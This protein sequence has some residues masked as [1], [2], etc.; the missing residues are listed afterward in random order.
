MIS[1]QAKCNS[2]PFSFNVTLTGVVSLNFEVEDISF[3]FFEVGDDIACLR[4]NV[5]QY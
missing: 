5:V 4:N 1:Y 2:D 3:S